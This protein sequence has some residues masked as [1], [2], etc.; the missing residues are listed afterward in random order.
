MELNFDKL[1]G[2]V[3][4]VIQDHKTNEVLMVG[5]MDK[6][7]YGKTLETGKVWYYSR[8][9]NKLWM[10]GET[11]GNVQ[12]VKEILVDCDEDTLVIKVEQ[13]GGAACHNGYESCFY[14]DIEGKVIGKK[15][16]DPEKVYSK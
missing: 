11:S 5:F 13:K 3:P 14:R 1:N 15:V 7:A 10:K 2:L 16:F 8:T 6:E 9:R 4:A 12:I